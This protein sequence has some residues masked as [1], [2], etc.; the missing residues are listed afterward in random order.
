MAEGQNYLATA[1]IKEPK[2]YEK[3]TE[4]SIKPQ[5]TTFKLW[6]NPQFTL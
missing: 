5:R 1:L 2:D 3:P 6:I 4:K